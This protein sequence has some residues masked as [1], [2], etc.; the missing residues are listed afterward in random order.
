MDVPLYPVSL[1]AY[2]LYLC[3]LLEQLDDLVLASPS[4]QGQS[5]SVI[6][7]DPEQELENHTFDF[8]AMR[9]YQ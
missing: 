9:K 3:C 8:E 7:G 6:G 4:G 1:S 5:D 2:S